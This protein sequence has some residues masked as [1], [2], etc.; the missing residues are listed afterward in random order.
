MLNFEYF[1]FWLMINFEFLLNSIANRMHL[2]SHHDHKLALQRYFLLDLHDKLLFPS[3]P[4]QIEKMETRTAVYNKYTIVRVSGK[5]NINYK[6]SKLKLHKE[7]LVKN[8]F[9]NNQ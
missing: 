7:V 5:V 9:N 6:V 8:T 2:L 4:Y 1:F 3:N